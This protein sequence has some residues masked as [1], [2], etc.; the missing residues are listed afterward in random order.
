MNETN[1]LA[2]MKTYTREAMAEAG[3]SIIRII[4]KLFSQIVLYITIEQLGS[5]MRLDNNQDSELV[6]TGL[7]LAFPYFYACT[8]KCYCCVLSASR[9]QQ[10]S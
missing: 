6:K 10:T 7:T 1:S 3:K 8:Q 2:V 4:F 5:K 9:L